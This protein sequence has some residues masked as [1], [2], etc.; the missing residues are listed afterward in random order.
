MSGLKVME[1]A[2]EV[3]QFIVLIWPALIVVGFACTCTVGVVLGGVTI[4]VTVLVDW[5]LAPVAVRV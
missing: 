3:V 2:L 5:P 4:T 1:T